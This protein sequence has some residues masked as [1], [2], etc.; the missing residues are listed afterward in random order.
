M[1]PMGLLSSYFAGWSVNHFK[2]KNL[3]ILGFLISAIAPIPAAVMSESTSYWASIFPSC[4]IGV[5][6]I[7][8]V[9]NVVSI[10]MMASVPPAAKSLAGGTYI[11]PERYD[12]RRGRPAC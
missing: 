6:G 1:G 8:L 10:S 11:V 4:M 5:I 7:S 12:T 9:Y 2:I 3:M